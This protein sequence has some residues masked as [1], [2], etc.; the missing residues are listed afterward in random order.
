MTKARVGIMQPYLFPYL[1]H[2]A[3]I[4]NVDHWY[5][6]D[7]T[8]YTPKTWMNRNR[9]L[10]PVSGMQ[11]F[12]VALSNSSIGIRTCEAKILNRESSRLSVL[13]KL[14]H[15]RREAPYYN[16]VIGLVDEVFSSCDEDDLV[17]LNIAGLQ[18]VCRYLG[19]PFSFDVCSKME[20]HLT[21]PLSAGEW[22]PA[23]CAAVGAKEYLNPI[24][25]R[26]L[27]NEADFSKQGVALQ[28]L[29]YE[30]Y[31]YGV[32]G[33]TFEPDLSVLDVLMWNSPE[34]VARHIRHGSKVISAKEIGF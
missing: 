2:F 24:G 3:L 16:E 8:Q 11:Y 5:V 18:M 34:S 28:F 29:E 30:K 25:G 21:Q 7:V 33:Y 31:L 10:H 20:L 22:A 27:F 32:H 12:T 14:S 15:Y 17:N 4:A 23:I 1:G 13:G 6:F 26:R 19:I 9:I